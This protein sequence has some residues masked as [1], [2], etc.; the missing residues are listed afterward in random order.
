MST[1]LIDSRGMRASIPPRLRAIQH[2]GS[3]A[4]DQTMDRA[5][6]S[7]RVALAAHRVIHLGRV[8]MRLDVGWIAFQRAQETS[9]CVLILLLATIEQAKP[10]MHLAVGGDNR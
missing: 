3:L 8:A 10:Q 6:M 7:L 9:Q 4:F 2:T 1:G 5:Q